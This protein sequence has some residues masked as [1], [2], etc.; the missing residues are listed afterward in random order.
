MRL[1]AELETLD[2]N[3]PQQCLCLNQTQ[4]EGEKG[5][6]FRGHHQDVVEQA[7]RRPGYCCL[8]GLRGL[9]KGGWAI[10]A[11]QSE[12]GS[13]A[14]QRERE[15][16][17]KGSQGIRGRDG[18]TS[19]R[20]SIDTHTTLDRVRKERRQ[21]GREIRWIGSPWHWIDLMFV[22]TCVCVCRYV[23]TNVI[24]KSQL[25]MQGIRVF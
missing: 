17:P 8:R 10:E 4:R 12:G 3:Y 22:C 15:R 16:E 5:G 13:G 7:S 19:T 9:A 20:S 24:S 14:G 21:G 23:W 11:N 1:S 6:T 18:S 25:V 2:T